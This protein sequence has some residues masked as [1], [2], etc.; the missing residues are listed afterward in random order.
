MSDA[1]SNL[2]RLRNI[3]EKARPA[4]R[5]AF[6]VE[7]EIVRLVKSG[8]RYEAEVRVLLADGAAD[9]AWPLLANVPLSTALGAAAAAGGVLAAVAP[10][11]R[12]AVSFFAGDPSRPF[13]SA[14][15]GETPAE[16]G[17]ADWLADTGNCRIALQAD[18]SVE[19][20]AAA[21]AGVTLTV[22]GVKIELTPTGGV[23][24]APEL[25]LGSSAAT[26]PAV[27][28]TQ[29]MTLFNTLITV[30]NQHVHQVSTPVGPGLAAPPA[31]PGTAMS[32]TQLS[33]VVKVL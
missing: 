26:E 5:E 20:E 28:G 16:A 22:G 1:R 12:V 9:P 6:P 31:T 24:T 32:A 27:L 10:G 18:G 33:T 14:V 17:D 3:L 23:L 11:T 19:V 8:G 30:F 2:L 15:F 4:T 25:K 13:V 29:L 21:T 7:G